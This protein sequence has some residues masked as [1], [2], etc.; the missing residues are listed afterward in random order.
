MFTIRKASKNLGKLLELLG[1]YKL[2]R[3]AYKSIRFVDSVCKLYRSEINILKKS[4]I[5]NE[6]T[7]KKEL[8]LRIDY[9][10]YL[11]MHFRENEG[12]EV[13]QESFELAENMVELK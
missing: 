11:A 9:S 6:E 3:E 2:S 12:I 8:A 13:L 10:Q 7:R 1:Q 5:K 4:N